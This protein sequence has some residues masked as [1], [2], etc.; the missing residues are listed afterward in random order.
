MCELVD[1]FHYYCLYARYASSLVYCTRPSVVTGRG[2][3]AFNA[4]SLFL[5]LTITIVSVWHCIDTEPELSQS[6]LYLTMHRP[7]AEYLV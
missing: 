7:T 6:H 1:G 2:L 5:S 4:T 3:V